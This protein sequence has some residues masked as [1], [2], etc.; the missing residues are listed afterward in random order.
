MRGSSSRGS[1]IRAAG[2]LLHPTSLPGPFGVGDLG[3]AAERFL[4]WASSARQTIWQ[5]LPLGPTGFGASPYGALSAFAGNPLLLSP[6][7]LVEDGLLPASA[8]EDVPDFPAERVEWDAARDWKER[9]LRCAWSR[10]GKSAALTAEL[11]RFRNAPEQRAWLSDWTLFAARRA[12]GSSGGPRELADEIAYQEF[13]Q[14]LFFRQ[15]GRLRDEATRRGISLFGDVPIYVSLDGADVSAHRELFALD[16]SGRA[17]E[18]AGVPP[19]FFSRTGQL[20]GYPLYRWDRMEED[21]FAWWIERLRAAFRLTDVVR[22]DHFRG[23]VGYWAVP[24][25]S[26]TAADGRW[27]PGPG[28]K[29]FDE[30]ARAIPGRDLV[31]EDLGTITSDVRALLAELGFP[32]MKVLQFAFFEPDSPYLPHRHVA[33]SV[34]YTGTHDNDT[35]RGWW[36]SLTEEERQRARDYLGTDG[37]EIEWDLIRAAYGSVA[38][39]A[40]VPVQDVFGLGSEARMNTPGRGEGNWSWRAREEDFRPDRA[41][42]LLRLAELTGRT[43]TSRT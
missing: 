17:L 27:R 38:E 13:L 26:A 3:P 30:V 1:D 12:T 18:V 40:I 37:R 32:G 33:N 16:A 42:R 14:L 43:G 19:D 22:L 31:A 25:E 41:A 15:W 23:F 4:D 39:R 8:L 11:D 6:E 28:R 7:R 29:L 9:L 5:V 20:W 21:R 36:G 2:L 35:A 24:S 10:S 34:V